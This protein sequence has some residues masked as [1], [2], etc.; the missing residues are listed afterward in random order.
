MRRCGNSSCAFWIAERT[1]SRLSRTA[2]AGRPTSVKFGR[3]PPRCTSM[4]TGGA[5]TPL[6]ARLCASA[7]FIAAMSRASVLAVGRRRTRLERRERA[8]ERL[9]LLARAQQHRALH[10]ELLARDQVEAAEARLQR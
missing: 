6:R 10:L 1:R 8:F 5:C 3:P 2:V 4:R 9:D 7:R